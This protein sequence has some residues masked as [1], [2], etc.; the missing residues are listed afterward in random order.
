MGS[1]AAYLAKTYHS[2]E[3]YVR[4]R[5]TPW[6]AFGVVAAIVALE[7]LVG[8][9]HIEQNPIARYI[10]KVCVALGAFVALMLIRQLFTAS[11]ELAMIT[12]EI[13]A[14]RTR[15]IPGVVES[16]Q[17]F[18]LH[19]CVQHLQEIVV[20]DPQAEVVIDCLGIDLGQTWQFLKE[21]IRESGSISSVNVQLLM[22]DSRR[23]SR[24]AIDVATWRSNAASNLREIRKWVRTEL[25]KITRAVRLEIRCYKHLP[26]VHGFHL[27]KPI[28][29]YYI[30]FCRWESP[31]YD[32]FGFGRRA[33]RRVLGGA[34]SRAA[35]DLVEIFEGQFQHDWINS[36][37]VDLGL[38]HQRETE[39]KK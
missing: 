37:P 14:I 23:A 34:R 4:R 16:Y 25:P 3:E 21:S 1:L 6:L 10:L 7:L 5:L 27:K 13:E 32:S 29:I 8:I 31:T 9:V 35:E 22:I 17:V 36:A 2:S 12:T 28:D 33:Y 11:A 38:E 39:A 26:V 30:S 20:K 19:D 15:D 24:Q 18:S